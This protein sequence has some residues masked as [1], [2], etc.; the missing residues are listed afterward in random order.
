[1]L[2]Y[3]VSDV[4]SNFYVV[5]EDFI[6]Y[7]FGEVL[8]EQQ[9]VVVLFAGDIGERTLLINIAQKLISLKDNLQVVATLG[10]HEFYNADMDIVLND[11]YDFQRILDEPRITVLDGTNKFIHKIDDVVFIG[12]TLWTNFNNMNPLMMNEAQREMN[13]YKCIYTQCYKRKINANRITNENGVHCK[14][15]F[16]MLKKH[17]KSKTVVLTHHVPYLP[18]AIVEP[19]QYAYYTDCS[20]HF[21]EL[22]TEELPNLWV[23]GHTHMSSDKTIQY[24]NGSVR[25]ISNQVGYPRQ[26]G[27]NGFSQ[28]AII[29]V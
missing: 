26:L 25:F 14:N 15:I 7:V 8:K 6:N 10:N 27:C 1:M 13:D 29:E 18:E 23:H 22:S 11:F 16:K 9:P 24:T 28:Y 5:N 3:P 20:K 17:A 4:H 2:V 19:I 21:N 12:G